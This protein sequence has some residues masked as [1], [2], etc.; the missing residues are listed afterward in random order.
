MANP[1]H[2]A[3]LT[4][5]AD[6][7]HQW[8]KERKDW[9]NVDLAGADLSGANLEGISLR[10]ANLR[11]V[12]FERAELFDSDLGHAD[13]SKANLV[14]AQLARA[15]LCVANL[16]GASLSQARLRGA[17]LFA[18]D[19]SC[20]DIAKADLTEAN[21]T[22]ARLERA[23]LYCA[24]MR[25]CTLVN[26]NLARANLTGT[27]LYGT[28]RDDWIINGVECKYV[29]LDGN[30]AVRSPA[31]R[32]FAPGEFEQIYK[33]LPTIEYVFQNGMTPLDPLI[34]NR[35]VQAIRDQN[36]E[37][38]LKIDSINAR[39][40]APSIK[41]T[42][43]RE[44]HKESALAEVTRVYEAKVQELAGRLDEARAFIQLLIDRPNSVHINNPTGPLA[45]AGST[46]N[47]DQHVEYITNL[48]DAIAALPEDSQTF[49]KVAKKTALGIIGDA[50][51]D[52]AKGQVKKA[53]M[54]ICELGKELGPVIVNTAAYTFFTTHLGQ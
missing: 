50:L 6:A 49:A 9:I 19:V 11:D 36:P 14:G 3:I 20:A 31:D 4:K 18:A 32:D 1:E 42:V 28:A 43:Q 7:W 22:N 34:M 45:I 29:F 2:L 53:A 38:D 54:Q 33:A 17:D 48:R 21:L 51:K 10:G 27:R 30:G 26:T 40:L 5:G 23:N 16:S 39:G 41:F 12:N 25:Y 46:I 47:I 35:V 8:R 44:E 13:L 37:Y 24:D 15:D 52:V